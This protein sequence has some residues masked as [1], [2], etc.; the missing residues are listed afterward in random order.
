MKQYTQIS[1]EERETIYNL[2]LLWVKQC[3]IAKELGRDPWTISR[4]LDRNKTILKGK[5]AKKEKWD[6]DYHYLPDRADMKTKARRVGKGWISP[7]ENPEVYRYVISGLT[8]NGWSP[9]IISGKMKAEYPDNLSMRISHECIYQ[10]IY[11]KAGEKLNMKSYLLRSH[12]KRKEKTGRSVRGVSKTRIPGRVDIDERPKSIE[13][14]EEFWNWEW[15]S[16]LSGIRAW[17]T[18]HTELE[19][20]SRFLMVKKIPQKTALLTLEAQKKIF[21]PL[22]M[23]ARRTTTLDNGTEN[24]EHTEL[25]KC[26]W[27]LVYYA[28]PYHS[29]ERGSNEH[30][31]GMIR[32]F[33]PKGTDFSLISDEQIQNVV[34][35]INNRPRKILWYRTSKEVFDHEIYLLSIRN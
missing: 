10:F 32:R 15:D 4:E 20:K 9:D 18:L 33:F 29:W 2:K 35:Y 17:A 5:N 28:K 13:T 1:L 21:S 7:M 3:K 6:S 27:I 22:P 26:V 24:V 8:E 30:A 14:R 16:V 19:R 25:T 34:D 12:R 23:L 11:S 31:N